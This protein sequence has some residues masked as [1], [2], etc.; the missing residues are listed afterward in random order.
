[1]TTVPHH[2]DAHARSSRPARASPPAGEGRP[3]RRARDADPP[4]PLAERAHAREMSSRSCRRSCSPPSSRPR[5]RRR[6]A[7]VPGIDYM[8]F[9]A[10][11]TL[12]LL[13]PISCMFAGIGVI[14]D[15]DSGA[16]RD[17]LAAPVPRPLLVL[18]NLAVALVVC[19][20]QVV[21]LVGAAPPARGRLR[22]PGVRHRSGSW[23]RPPC[24][25]SRCTASRRRWRTS[26][27]KQEEYI[28]VVP[29]DRDRPVVL[30]GLAVPDH[31][32]ARLAP[33]GRQGPPAHPHARAHAVRPRRPARSRSARHLGHERPDDD[34]AAEPRCRRPVRRGADRT[35]APRVQPVGGT[36]R[37][38][39]ISPTT[40]GSPRA[41]TDSASCRRCG[42]T[43]P[44][45]RRS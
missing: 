36:V 9:V 42:P 18:A 45:S 3:G 7:M 44:S 14:V 1:M 12:G 21:A 23:V 8:S 40:A 43:A 24:S 39:P 28:G 37:A 15:R 26:I 30:R 11:G 33:V 2:P 22:T 5:W 38:W 4:A 25:R 27:R 29:V 6:W 16:Q 19:S 13:L 31:V 20:L 32:A 10:V 34:G 17:L 41:T 35:L